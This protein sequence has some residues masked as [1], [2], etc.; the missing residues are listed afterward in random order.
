[1]AAYC[2]FYSAEIVKDYPHTVTSFWKSV[3]DIDMVNV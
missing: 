2:G 1:M 3:I